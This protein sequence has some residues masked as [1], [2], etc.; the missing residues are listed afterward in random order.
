MHLY[1]NSYDDY[2]PSHTYHF[3]KQ[4][5]DYLGI[6]V[7]YTYNGGYPVSVSGRSV[8]ICPSS[9]APLTSTQL[10]LTNYVGTGFEPSKR[11]LF[12][13][14]YGG[15]AWREDNGTTLLTNDTESSH[16]RILSIPPASVLLFEKQAMG[17]QGIRVSL[18]PAYYAK[19]A[20][21]N[22]GGH[23]YSCFL[24]S[25]MSYLGGDPAADTYP[26]FHQSRGNSLCAD[27]HVKT[28]KRTVIFDVNMIEE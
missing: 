23:S 22:F 11:N 1:S 25:Q 6:P 21:T 5:V 27:G 2:L 28:H 9:K 15:M 18:T 20:Y 17:T 19:I 12:T 24:P 3:T 7:P 14:R 10:A 8:L 13:R 4:L 26:F 16:R